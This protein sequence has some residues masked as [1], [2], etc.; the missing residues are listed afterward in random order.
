MCLLA[1]Y[2]S[3]LE[4]CPFRYSI[5]FDWAVCFPNIELYKLLIFFYILIF[6]QLFHSQL[7]SPILRI[8]F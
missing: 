1:I 3:S 6:G 4:K 7:F 8:V 2:M 5:F